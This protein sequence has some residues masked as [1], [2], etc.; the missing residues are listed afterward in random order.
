[1]PK[2]QAAPAQ[3]I[4]RIGISSTEKAVLSKAQKEFN[5]LTKKIETLE[6]ETVKLRETGQKLQ[7]RIQTELRPLVQKHQAMLVDL[8]K[9]LD[10]MHSTKGLTK[11]HR[12]K[13]A[14]IIQDIAFDLIDK[15]YDDLKAIYDKYDE[16]GFEA[17]NEEAEQATAE[18]MKQ[19]ISA[20]F[21]IDFEDDADVST[22]EKLNA[23]LREK[24]QAQHEAQERQQQ[25]DQ[26]RRARRAKTAKQ[27]EREEKRETEARNIT[28]AVRTLYMDLVKVFHPD[29]EPD[30]VEKVRKTEVM[31]RVTA[32]YE[33][34]DL[35]TLLK[36]QLEFNRIDQNHLENLAD[37]Q[38]KYYNKILREQVQELEAEYF[39]EQQRV[40]SMMGGGMFVVS[41]Y[42]MEFR[43]NQNIAQMKE[44]VK[45]LK[46]DLFLLTDVDMLKSW[47]RNY[48]INR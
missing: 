17:A 13:I 12:T 48:R 4:V 46:D 2:K 8:V 10:R 24:M 33:A 20:M 40:G 32:A 1:M 31:Q 37:E 25:Q 44:Q 39:Q 30:E 23:Y 6:K 18:Q 47:L 7:T 5:R 38:L 43:L 3:T 22:P 19:R 16:Q 15:G 21:G 34:S 35:L 42:G 45:Q 28:K 27:Q 29:R 9:L 41:T 14:H 11:P 36:L 26:E